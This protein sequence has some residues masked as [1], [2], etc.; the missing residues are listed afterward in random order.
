MLKVL[1][2]KIQNDYRI[3]AGYGVAFVLLLTSYI[4]T[5]VANAKVQEQGRQV[6]HSNSI[7][8]HIE[9]LMSYLKDAETSV[10]GFGLMREES[11][12]KPY[13]E[14]LPLVK[15]SFDYLKKETK[16]NSAQQ[17]RL[18]ALKRMIDQRFVYLEGAYV[19]FKNPHFKI[20]DSIRRG[21]F[22]GKVLMDSIRFLVNEI[23]YNEEA[24][25]SNSTANLK[26]NYL[27]LNTIIVTSLVLAFLFAT[28]G[29]ITYL[30]EKK[31][32][33]EADEKVVGYQE[34]LELR[35]R[36]LDEANKELK[37]MRLSEKFATTGRIARS[38]AHEV[39][40]PLTNI[41][42]ATSQ[43]LAEYSPVDGSM[44]MLFD[45]VNRNSKRINQLIT[46]LLTA[47][48]FAELNYQ[49]VSLNELAEEALQLAQDRLQLKQIAVQK[50]LD[51]HLPMIAADREK[52]IIALL[53]LLLNAIEAIEDGNGLIVITTGKEN[54]LTVIQI[55]DNGV[56]MGKEALSRLFEPYFTTKN[57]GNGLGLT[58][59]QN[60]ILNHKGTV[61]VESEEG[62][63]TT[64]TIRF[65]SLK[66]RQ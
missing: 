7:I 20:T 14:S 36:E 15:Q 50:K 1:I 11:F 21:P 53:N 22:R 33:K 52:M 28:L 51:A 44:Q 10:R 40:N 30:R 8:Q 12:L 17:I 23:K 34:Q 38:I 6:N 47:T 54:D 4:L 65:H 9:G 24:D 5:L 3:K 61:Q 49:P 48:R 19:N 25:L 39:R 63:G 35:I 42:L 59:T 37:A 46:E 41:D 31:A 56:G 58:N 55:Q 13:F 62:W 57:K 27:A 26:S 60:I 43:I 64:F 16:D 66:D 18:Y 29:F 32:R 2:N 45:M